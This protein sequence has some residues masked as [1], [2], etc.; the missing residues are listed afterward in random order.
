MDYSGTGL[1]V[2]RTLVRAQWH[3]RWCIRPNERTCTAGWHSCLPA[4]ESSYVNDCVT[5]PVRF[6]PYITGDVCVV[7]CE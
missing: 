3:S 5:E 2:E 6:M 1:S 7:V 4:W